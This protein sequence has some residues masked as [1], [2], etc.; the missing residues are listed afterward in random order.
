I[1]G[2]TM[3][4]V[5]GFIFDLEF[6]KKKARRLVDPNMSA[7]NLVLNSLA[8]DYDRNPMN[9]KLK[10][11]PIAT[12]ES[13]FD[14]VK[15]HLIAS[16][17][18]QSGDNFTATVKFVSKDHGTPNPV[19]NG[20]LK[21]ALQNGA[22]LIDLELDGQEYHAEKISSVRDLKP[23]LKLTSANSTKQILYMSL[24]GSLM[25][26]ASIQSPLDDLVR[27]PQGA[28]AAWLFPKLKFMVRDETLNQ[29]YLAI[30]P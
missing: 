22:V 25:L 29:E 11:T 2:K 17:F 18:I 15:T 27:L 7:L 23:F 12:Y 14:A 6:Q 8:P 20:Q 16:G 13:W 26:D 3:Q 19:S 9:P 10:V 5:L 4:N 28:N 24:A 21:I 1:N 30:I